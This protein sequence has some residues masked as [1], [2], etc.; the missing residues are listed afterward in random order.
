MDVDLEIHAPGLDPHH[1]RWNYHVLFMDEVHAELSLI[2]ERAREGYKKKGRGTVFVDKDQWM[3][4]IRGEWNRS[5]VTFPCEFVSPDEDGVH[6]KFSALQ[7]GFVQLIQQ[8]NPE[9]QVVL[10]VEH[11]GAGLLST[12]LIRS[13]PED[14][15]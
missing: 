9:N 10:T 1:E 15:A 3:T 5:D 11:H 13:D 2:A 6:K 8:Y 14:A 12:Y 4:I 7:D